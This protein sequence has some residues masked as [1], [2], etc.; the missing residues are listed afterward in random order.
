MCKI[1][2]FTK[3]LRETLIPLLK[4][5]ESNLVEAVNILKDQCLIFENKIQPDQVFVE[6]A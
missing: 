1:P 2:N 5:A 3:M 6:L 4:E